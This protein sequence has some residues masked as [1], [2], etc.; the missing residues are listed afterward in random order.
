MMVYPGNFTNHARSRWA[1]RFP[2]LCPAEEFATAKLAKKG[3][4]AL[5]GGRSKLRHGCR[6]RV[7][8]HGAIFVLRNGAIVTVMRAAFSVWS[9]RV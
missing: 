7:S 2:A 6:Y 4:R 9:H 5:V 3:I 8:K 1:E